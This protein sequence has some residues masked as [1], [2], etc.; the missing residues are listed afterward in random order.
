MTHVFP[1]PSK[2]VLKVGPLNDPQATVQLMNP[3]GQIIQA[4]SWVRENQLEMDI[5]HL[6]PGKYFVVLNGE[7]EKR[8]FPFMKQ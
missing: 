2:N 8:I 3:M 7:G 1:N 6:N 4:R 5:H